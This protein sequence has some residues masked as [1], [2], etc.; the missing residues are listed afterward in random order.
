MREDVVFKG[1]RG[2]IQLLLSDTADFADILEQLKGKLASAN[3]FFRRGATIKL[4]A[5]LKAEEHTQIASLL[6]E[7]GLACWETAKRAESGQAAASPAPA[8]RDRYETRALVVNK[9]LRSGQKVAYDGSVVVIGDVNP[10]AQIVAGQDIIILGACRGV[11]HAGAYGDATAT[12][13]ANKIVAT[14]L[15]IAGV[16]SRSPDD[17]D[18]PDCV[19]IARIRDGA[20]VIEPANR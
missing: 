13:T 7:H 10:G 1:V 12:I 19:E 14:Q 20:V 16:I 3:D 17:L 15:R 4:P 18:K 6:A 5:T 9:T 2:E 8:G 11:A